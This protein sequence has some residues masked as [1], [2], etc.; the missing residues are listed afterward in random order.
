MWY[1]VKVVSSVEHF[2]IKNGRPSTEDSSTNSITGAQS[3]MVTLHS[4]DFWIMYIENIPNYIFQR[5][6][7][8]FS[9]ETLCFLAFFFANKKGLLPLPV[10]RGLGVRNCRCRIPAPPNSS[11]F[12]DRFHYKFPTQLGRGLDRI[13]FVIF[14]SPTTSPEPVANRPWPTSIRPVHFSTRGNPLWLP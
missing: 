11:G 13:L 5:N 9:F 1:Y 3:V 6:I 2:S 12:L 8:L 4:I 14:L 10:V 7:K